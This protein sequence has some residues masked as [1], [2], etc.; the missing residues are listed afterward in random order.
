MSR[1]TEAT[2]GVADA[3]GRGP[4]RTAD[5]LISAVTAATGATV[6]ATIPLSFPPGG[7]PTAFDLAV[8]QRVDPRLDARPW[9]AEVLSLATDTGVVLA[10]LCGGVA[11]FAWQRRW[12][13]TATMV[14]VPEAAV[15]INA[16]ALKP[17]WSRPLYDY[18]AY[19]S[20]HTV[21]L[22]A[23]VTT[24]VLLLRSARARTVIVALTVAAW[25]GAGIGMI[26]LDYHLTTDIVGGAAA[27]IALAIALYWVAVYI[28][29][30]LG[31]RSG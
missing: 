31:A 3:R 9:I 24:L 19:P 28:G 21:H 10:I 5:P 22:V 27:A 7:G 12:W 17:F 6:A 8:D 26:A 25:C 2:A 13:E 4:E 18:F 20:G 15:A 23:V 30:A 11:W 29:R 16:W 1:P 14:L